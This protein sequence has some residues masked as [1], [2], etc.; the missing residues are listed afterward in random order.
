MQKVKSNTSTVESR[1]HVCKANY[2]FEM[3]CHDFQ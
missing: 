2:N 1:F 3:T